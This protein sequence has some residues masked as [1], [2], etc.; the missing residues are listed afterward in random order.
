MKWTAQRFPWIYV[1]SCAEGGCSSK[2]NELGND[3]EMN[4]KTLSLFGGN[5]SLA[6]INKETQLPFPTVTKLSV[7]AMGSLGTTRK[8]TLNVTCYTDDELVE[9]QKCFFIPGL[10]VR[11][12]WGWSEDCNGN[13]PPP[14]KDNPGI[15]ASLMVCQI[16]KLRQAHANYDGFQ[17]IVSNFGY[18]LTQDNVWECDIEIISPADPFDKSKVSNSKCPCPREIETDAGEKVKS[19]GPV[20]AAFAD[21]YED[22]DDHCERILR[23][24]R[25]PVTGGALHR[26]VV[27]D[28]E[29]VERTEDGGEKDGSW[30]DGLVWGGEETTETWISFGAFI[31][32]LNA[33]SI[34]NNLKQAKVESFL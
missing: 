30:Y 19:F 27:Y 1:L 17:G 3:P 33:M 11:V 10:N 24:C 34:P 14:A 22:G 4:G 23:K 8:A 25:N 13:P 6:A 26:W 7:K 5:P 32:I 16:N 18:N 2:Y 12:Q 31:D 9:L 28:F 20:Y 29:G 21:M 15:E